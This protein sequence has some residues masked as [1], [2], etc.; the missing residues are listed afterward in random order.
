MKLID[1]INYKLIIENY[2][3]E[4]EILK[5]H[6]KKEKYYII[7]KFLGV[8]TGIFLL[9]ICFNNMNL[10]SSKIVSEDVGWMFLAVFGFVLVF[11]CVIFLMF[12]IDEIKDD[13]KRYEKAITRLNANQS[14]ED[15]ALNIS[16]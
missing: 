1:N 15:K 4:I 14:I 7:L 8:I 16:K 13:K 12:G 9:L 3:K 11:A 2:K 10:K 5:N 6:I